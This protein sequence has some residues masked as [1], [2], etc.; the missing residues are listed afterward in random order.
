MLWTLVHISPEGFIPWALP[1]D[2]LQGATEEI[3]REF[4]SECSNFPF[5]KGKSRTQGFPHPGSIGDGG[6]GKFSS[7]FQAL[8]EFVLAGTEYQQK[9]H[10][11]EPSSLPPVSPTPS[12]ATPS[13]DS[14][15]RTKRVRTR[16]GGKKEV[17]VPARKKDD[18]LSVVRG[19]A[20][21][22]RGLALE[23]SE[24]MSQVAHDVV[25]LPAHPNSR[26]V[27]ITALDHRL[28]IES[29]EKAIR[30]V[31]HLH[32]GLYKD[33]LY[34]PVEA[35]ME[36][37][38]REEGEDESAE[39]ADQPSQSSPEQHAETT[40][41]EQEMSDENGVTATPT[42]TTGPSHQLQGHAVLELCCS[43]K[44]STVSSALLSC[45]AL[46]CPGDDEGTICVTA[47]GDT[48]TCGD[49]ESA[50][51]VLAVYLRRKLFT[52]EEESDQVELTER[53][54]KTLA[55]IFT[56]SLGAGPDPA[57]LAVSEVTAD[58]HLFL[59][60][61]RDGEHVQTLAQDVWTEFGSRRD[62]DGEDRTLDVEQFLR[63]AVG[64]GSGEGEGV[65]CLWKG[66]FAC[67][68]DLHF[69]RSVVLFVT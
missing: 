41:R 39:S 7:Y 66:L 55:A 44:L 59:S 17:E 69:E 5:P 31:C 4:E 60:G 42:S 40:P 35:V 15:K 68:Y 11:L 51:K 13:K 61:Y 8:L 38:G 25:S 26:L 12:G 30:K 6:L 49:D 57:R 37:E 36:E 33:Q 48:L 65:R 58:L 43:K 16:K 50:N 54:K 27:V 9:F 22:L 2:F 23:G 29:T 52:T 21:L 56:S 19:A 63:W 62:K 3:A 18:W 20:G 1:A 28:E 24:Y 47:V 53:A 32:G 10:E 34:L 14:T 45:P 46:Q 64:R 67:G